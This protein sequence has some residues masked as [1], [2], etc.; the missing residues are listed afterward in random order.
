MMNKSCDAWN[1]LAKKNGVVQYECKVLGVMNDNYNQNSP[2][3]AFL[4]DSL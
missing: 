2:L 1:K 4:V 3:I